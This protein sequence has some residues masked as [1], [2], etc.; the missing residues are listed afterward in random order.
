ME[1]SI[2]PIE[3]IHERDVDLILL[4]ELTT[5]NAFCEW[6]INEMEFPN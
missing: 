4:E 1:D 3:S 6:L 5:D 2:L